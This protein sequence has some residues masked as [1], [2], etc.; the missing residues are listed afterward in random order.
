MNIIKVRRSM[1]K[2]L[3]KKYLLYLLRWQLSTP[4]LALCTFWLAGLGNIWAAIVANLIGGLL[5][6][7]VDKKIFKEVK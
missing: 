4:I 2:S 3:I 6:F 7:W 1:K 5:F